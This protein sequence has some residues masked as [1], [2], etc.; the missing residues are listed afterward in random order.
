MSLLNIDGKENSYPMQTTQVPNPYWPKAL[1]KTKNKSKH[2]EGNL[3][4]PAS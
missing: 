3:S 4:K 2:N 1:V